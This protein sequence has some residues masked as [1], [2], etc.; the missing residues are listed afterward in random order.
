M[1]VDEAIMGRSTRSRR[2]HAAA[3]FVACP[4][5]GEGHGVQ[6]YQPVATVATVLA[7]TFAIVI[8]VRLFA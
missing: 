6:G 8:A 1:A 3:G 4:A 2:D 7:A 5:D